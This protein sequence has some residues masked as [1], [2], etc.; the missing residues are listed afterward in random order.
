MISLLSLLFASIFLL[1]SEVV[2][3]KFHYFNNRL[4]GHSKLNHFNAKGRT[5][6]NK[7]HDTEEIKRTNIIVGLNPALQRIVQLSSS[8]LEPGE[9]HRA[10]TVQ[11]G[12]GKMICSYYLQPSIFKSVIISVY[13][14]KG[15]KC[16]NRIKLYWKR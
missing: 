6:M 12:I 15:A 14:R 2:V 10:L 3:A 8:N 11:I 7:K 9:V 5:F 13:R 4:V 1:Y 16:T